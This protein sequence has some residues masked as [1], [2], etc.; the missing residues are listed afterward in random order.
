MFDSQLAAEWLKA[1]KPPERIA[2]SA[3][4]EREIRLAASANA[5][6]GP[7]RLTSYQREIVD[8]IADDETEFIVLMLSSQVGKSLAVLAMMAYAIEIGRAHV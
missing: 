1:F 6:P 2:P 8:A 5:L 4:A 3:F 7:L